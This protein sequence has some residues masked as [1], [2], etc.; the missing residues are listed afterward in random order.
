MK[1]K[2]W[3]AAI[4]GLLED[5]DLDVLGSGVAKD[6]SELRDSFN[7]VLEDNGHSSADTGCR[8]RRLKR[9]LTTHNGGQLEFKSKRGKHRVWKG[10][11]MVALNFFLA[12]IRRYRERV[13]NIYI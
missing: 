6:L 5:V 2:I 3:Q 1:K 11:Q 10:I 13:P 8:N 7:V 4:L 12:H 9:I